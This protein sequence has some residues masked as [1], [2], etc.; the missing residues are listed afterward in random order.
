VDFLKKYPDVNGRYT[1][2]PSISPE[3]EPEIENQDQTTNVV[4]NA[5]GEIAICKEVLT[6]LLK[7]Y[8]LLG[9]EDKDIDEYKSVL[10][11][12]PDY[13]INEDGALA[14]WAYPGFGDNYNHRHAS[15]LYPVY[16]G[17]EITPENT[18]DLYGAAKK[19]LEKRLEAGLGNNSAHGFMHISLVAARLRNAE[20]MSTM[21]TKFASLPFVNS[22]FITCHNP[23]PRIY[24]LD[25]CFSMPAVMTEMLV[26]SEPGLIE[27]LPATPMDM[28]PK[29]TIS[30][31]LARGGIEIV[32]LHWND[33]LGLINVRLKSKTKQSI[34]FQ[35]GPIM[36]TASAANPEQRSLISGKKYGPWTLD[37]PAGESVMLHCKY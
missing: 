11:K 34:Q 30:G 20:L 33:A 12:L 6:N 14:E 31:L 37:L 27:I 4:P 22:S 24:N 15:H 19:A 3:N 36:R 9:I 29:G 5:T 7:S 10:A 28:F 25:A 21:L 35:L 18:P 13:V 32:S 1:F 26:Y 8:E 17:L 2:Y 16:P 23:G